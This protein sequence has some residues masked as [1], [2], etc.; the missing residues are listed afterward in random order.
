[1]SIKSLSNLKFFILVEAL[2]LLLSCGLGVLVNSALPMLYLIPAAAYITLIR[3]IRHDG[4]A[5]KRMGWFWYALLM[6]AAIFAPFLVLSIMFNGV[7]IAAYG[8]AISGIAALIITTRRS[9]TYKRSLKKAEEERRKRIAAEEAAKKRAAEE[10]RR[11]E[12][13]E[14]QAYRNSSRSREYSDFSPAYSGSYRREEDIYE[15]EERKRRER[16]ED[17]YR[18]HVTIE[19]N[20]DYFMRNNDYGDDYW[21]HRS[22]ELTVSRREAQALVQ[23][24]PEAIISRCGYSNRELIRNISFRTPYGLYDQ[25]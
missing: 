6:G 16:L 4:Y 7:L 10:R 8:F 11:R 14:A 17:W 15:R 9:V 3:M 19:V 13:E 24:G 21:D 23:A 2:A 1:M 20:F 12:Q 22:E 25:P 18:D 5:G